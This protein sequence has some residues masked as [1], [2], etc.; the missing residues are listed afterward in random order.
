MAVSCGCV[1]RAPCWRSR[2]W[3]LMQSGGTTRG[4]KQLTQ[5]ASHRLSLRAGWSGA[6]HEHSK[7]PVPVERAP[8]AS[9]L[10]HQPCRFAPWPLDSCHSLILFSCCQGLEPNEVGRLLRLIHWCFML[11][12]RQLAG[13][14]SGRRSLVQDRYYRTGAHRFFRG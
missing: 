5:G 6:T 11:D 13:T 3:Q 4:N 10:S 8:V 14:S 9:W 2:C 1:V 12:L 7:S